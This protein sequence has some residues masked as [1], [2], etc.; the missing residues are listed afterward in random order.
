M[1]AL[2]I[3]A[4]VALCAALMPLRWGWKAFPFAVMASIITTA[5]LAVAFARMLYENG[6]GAMVHFNVLHLS[7]ACALGAV[8]FAFVRKARSSGLNG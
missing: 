6:G 3:A 8:A 2:S 4:L 1:L 7:V 5:L